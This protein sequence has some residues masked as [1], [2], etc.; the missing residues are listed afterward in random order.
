MNANRHPIFI[1][2]LLLATAFG[3]CA[4]YAQ[5]PPAEKILLT[6]DRDVYVAGETLFFTVRLLEGAPGLPPAGNRLVYVLIRDSRNHHFGKHCLRLSDGYGYGS[7]ALDDTLQSGPC[8]LMAFTNTMRNS[9]E[10][11]YAR[12]EVFV[13]NLF[14]EKPLQLMLPESATAHP[15]MALA[16]YPSGDPQPLTVSSGKR[17]FS[18]G[19]TIPIQIRCPAS[20]AGSPVR[21][22]VSLREKTPADDQSFADEPVASSHPSAEAAQPKYLPETDQMILRGS[23]FQAYNGAAAV[24]KKIV[25]S[26]PDTVVNLR[27][28]VS[29]S[30]GGFVFR[31]NDYYYDREL[32]LQALP[33]PGE[34]PLSL[35]LEDKF[36]FAAPTLPVQ[37]WAGPALQPY[38][39]ESRAIVRVKKSYGL[40]P[41]AQ[42]VSEPSARIAVPRIYAAPGV[43]MLPSDYLPLPDFQ[44]I[45]RELLP[46][47]KLRKNDE[48]WQLSL[49]DSRHQRYFDH[50]PAVFYNGILCRDTRQL[51]PLGS[52][53][54]RSMEV[55][56]T[57]V[58]CSDLIFSNG[59]LAVF[60]PGGEAPFFA[61]DEPVIRFTVSPR[62]S[63]SLLRENL[64]ESASGHEPDFRQLLLWKP[65]NH[66]PSGGS[67]ELSAKASDHTGTFILD[68]E[69]ISG[70]GQIIRIKQEIQ[71]H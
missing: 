7:I 4:G 62:L 61:P 2:L 27:Y 67:L 11:S 24:Q 40:M 60:T 46:T 39:D 22:S 41:G 56:N 63:G 19:E 64:P 28:A 66:L 5:Q 17:D 36:E 48:T 71:I 58:V 15:G 53:R 68:V 42:P 51:L 3:S 59:I 34:G 38:L 31:L 30:A 18:A 54:L 8:E 43:R 44:E 70:S 26:A 47:V 10:A 23:V 20:E 57:A 55:M 35:T 37:R 29:D 14:D 6:T 52:A 49:A 45:V 16:E 13:A 65:D 33:D 21:F 1:L 32:L 9:G 50:D 69:G 25:L 12:H